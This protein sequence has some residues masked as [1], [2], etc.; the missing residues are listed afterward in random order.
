MKERMCIAPL[1][2]PTSEGY[3]GQV[4]RCWQAGVGGGVGGEGRLGEW[5][6]GNDCESWVDYVASKVD[7]G[8]RV[9]RPGCSV[10]VQMQ[11]GFPS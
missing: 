11:V 6:E 10:R 3:A 9:S 8:M 2:R 4:G 5:I 1:K 7:V